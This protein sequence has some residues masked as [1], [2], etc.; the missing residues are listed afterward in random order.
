MYQPE[1][2]VMEIIWAEINVP[3]DI[4]SEKEEPLQNTLVNLTL[5]RL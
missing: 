1:E 4:N 5:R 3:E 2:E